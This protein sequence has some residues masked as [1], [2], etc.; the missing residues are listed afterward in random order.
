[1]MT[2]NKKLGGIL[3]L[4]P[5][6]TALVCLGIGRYSISFTDTI[7]VLFSP[8]TE[9][10]VAE[11]AKKADA[12]VCDTL[13]G[14]GAFDAYSDLY[15]GMIGMHG[16]KTSNLGVSKCD[17]L[18]ALGARFSDRVIS[19]A[20]MFASNAKIVHIDVD[21]AEINKNIKTTASVVGDL[22]EVLQKLNASLEQQNHSEWIAEIKEMKETMTITV[23]GGK[24][25]V[26]EDEITLDT[27]VKFR[28]QTITPNYIEHNVMVTDML[29]PRIASVD[30][31]L[32]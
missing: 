16:T 24:P 29:K 26:K 10:E 13:M 2:A 20:N 5:F 23:F 4:L 21:A 19:K 27:G 9:K 12:P 3:I 17:L 6:L 25:F 14:K 7:G 31:V 8:F 30:L 11:F 32:E 1:M 18:I 28:I 22:K 15:T